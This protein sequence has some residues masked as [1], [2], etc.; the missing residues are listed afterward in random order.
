MI[1]C[2]GHCGILPTVF[3][4]AKTCVLGIWTMIMYHKLSCLNKRQEGGSPRSCIGTLGEDLLS[5]F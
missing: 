2:K 5:G 3:L 1:K 4:Q